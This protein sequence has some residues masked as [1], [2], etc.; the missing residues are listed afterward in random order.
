MDDPTFAAPN[1]QGGVT[2]L[3][4]PPNPWKGHTAPQDFSQFKSPT[5]FGEEMGNQW[6]S[7]TK[8]PVD[9]DGNE[10]GKLSEAENFG[11]FA[12]KTLMK[13]LPK[14]QHQSMTSSNQGG[15][16]MAPFSSGGGA[17]GKPAVTWGFGKHTGFVPQ[18]I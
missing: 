6:D 5:T 14:M 17:G 3:P 13:D 9:E 7:W 18:G 8:R 16:M 12:L 10:T 1:W 4:T 11:A 15:P 2:R